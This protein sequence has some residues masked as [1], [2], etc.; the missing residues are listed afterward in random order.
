M[1]AYRVKDGYLLSL[2]LEGNVGQGM[3]LLSLGLEGIGVKDGYLLSI[4]LE[5]NEGQKCI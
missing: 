1:R 4:G 5:G 3:H 2:G